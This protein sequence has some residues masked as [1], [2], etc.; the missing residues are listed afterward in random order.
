M[1]I[2][3]N[4]ERNVALQFMIENYGFSEEELE[5]VDVI[6]FVEDFE[7]RVRDFSAEEV[8]DILSA[9]KDMYVDDGTTVLYSIFSKDGHE[10]READVVNRMGLYLNNGT[11]NQ[12]LIFDF[13]ENV[14]YINNAEPYSLTQQQSDQ[15]REL[16]KVC[17]IFEWDR[18]TEGDEEESTGNFKWELVFQIASG[19]YCTYDGYTQDGSNLPDTFNDF[20][21]GIQHIVSGKD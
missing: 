20:L 10:L 16:P 13:E 11:M 14:Y 15:L 8:R 3:D 9:Q 7:L 4:D 12:R 18:H 21:D 5:G 6:K 1:P 17:K 19:D 2:I